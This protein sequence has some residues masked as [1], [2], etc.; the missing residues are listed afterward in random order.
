MTNELKEK[1]P[2][3]YVDNKALYEEYVRYRQ[4]WKQAEDSGLERPQ[5]SNIIAKAIIQIATNLANRYNFVNYTYKGEMIGDAIVK[6]VAKAHLFD[7]EI[8]KNP[9]AY[10]TQICYWEMVNRIK[11]EHKEVSIKSRMIKENFNEEFLDHAGMEGEEYRNNFVE[12][13][14]E[15]DAYKDYTAEAKEKKSKKKKEDIDIP[16]LEEFLEEDKDD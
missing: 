12:F 4:E 2:I 9:F 14:K 1:R 11:K 8:T 3:D 10:L 15:N 16:V 7:P 5:I 13:L 6:C